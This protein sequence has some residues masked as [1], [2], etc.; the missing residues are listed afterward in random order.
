MIPLRDASRTPVRFPVQIVGGAFFGI[1]TAHLFQRHVNGAASPASSTLPA[2]W[3]H[4]GF[5]QRERPHR[6]ISLRRP[7]ATPSR[8]VP[9]NALSLKR[10]RLHPARARV[11]IL[12]LGRVRQETARVF[13]G[14]IAEKT[15]RTE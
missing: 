9:A 7:V 13:A 11:F 14:S 8:P 1:L 2:A 5:R 10:M 4:G 6:V 3:L 12:R 15:L